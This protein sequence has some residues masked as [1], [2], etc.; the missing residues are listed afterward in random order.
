M[1]PLES[2]NYEGGYNLGKKYKTPKIVVGHNVSF[3]RARVKEQYW[4]ES[5]ALRF[6]D[7]MSLHI[8]V[9]GITSFQRAILKSNKEIPEDDIVW[10]NQSSLNSLAEVYR[11]YCDK[12]LKKDLRNTFVEGSLDDIKADFQNLMSY[13]ASDVLATNQ[14]LKKLF[15]LFQ[16]RFSHPATLA[17]MLELGSAYL[18]VNSNWTRYINECNLTYEDLNIESKCLLAERANNACKMAHE[19]AFEKDLWMWDQDWSAQELKLNSSAAA[20]KSGKIDE[21]SVNFYS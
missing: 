5:T 4:I 14:V 18:P 15:P 1:I 20:K 10:S 17:G 3:D 7:T 6:I 21:V 11:L 12:E 2:S 19:N 9:S 13:C 8:C 16:E